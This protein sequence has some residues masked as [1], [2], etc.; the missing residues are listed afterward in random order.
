[1]TM[2]HVQ[3]E[4]KAWFLVKSYFFSFYVDG[5]LKGIG[6]GVHSNWSNIRIHIHHPLPFRILFPNQNIFTSIRST[7]LPNLVNQ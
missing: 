4:N 5:N 6:Y 3:F 1:M 7:A 2:Y